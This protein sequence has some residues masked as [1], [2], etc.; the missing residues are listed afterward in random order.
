MSAENLNITAKTEKMLPEDNNLKIFTNENLDNTAMA[1][2]GFQTNTS[3]IMQDHLT[4]FKK[5]D[6]VDY[7]MKQATPHGKK[8]DFERGLSIIHDS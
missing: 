6:S 5:D 4:S 2:S 1:P 7:L 8:D 3:A